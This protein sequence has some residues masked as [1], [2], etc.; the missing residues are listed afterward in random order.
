MGWDLSGN[1][2]GAA[3][4]DG[5]DGADGAPGEPGANADPP[6]LYKQREAQM[7]KFPGS[8]TWVYVAMAAPGTLGAITSVDDADGALGNFATATTLN[9]TNGFVSAANIM[10]RDW[11]GGWVTR[12]KTG[13]A[14]DLLGVRLWAGLT[15][16]DLALVATPTTQHVA[17]FRYDTVAD[18]AGGAFWRCITNAGNSDVLVTVTDVAI[19]A[20]T[21]YDLRIELS[22]TDVKF[23]V[24]DVLKATHA[25][26]LPGATTILG[27]TVKVTN[28]IAATA[29]NFKCG[30]MAFWHK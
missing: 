5:E 17:A 23:Y 18:S 10:R 19:A 1:I 29:R 28:L 13:A 3:G 24:N 22:A 6:K 21:A 7:V 20:A 12:V 8:T 11:L 16:A 9:A 25:T 15:S 26:K 30:R 4:A 27:H 2:R 14:T